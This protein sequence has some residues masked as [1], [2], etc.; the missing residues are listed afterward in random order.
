MTDRELLELTRRSP[1]EGYRAV[2][3][4]Y[5][6][7]V[8]SIV[9]RILRNDAGEQDI[10]EC[11]ADTF[12]EVVLHM[13]EINRDT[14]KAYLGTA[15]KHRALSLY[16]TLRRRNCHTVPLDCAEEL[17]DGRMVEE[18]AE[19]AQLRQLLLQEIAALGEPDASILIQK[20]YYGRRSAEIAEITGLSPSA[21]RKRCSRA[22]RRLKKTLTGWEIKW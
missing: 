15:A 18:T 8:Y 22:V 9:F 4:Q 12:A 21:V 3:E 20:Y 19:A 2:F 6:H 16:R 14:L 5:F 17:P 13:N 7:Y 11:V 1:N 10:E